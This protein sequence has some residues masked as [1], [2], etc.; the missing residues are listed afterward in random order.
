MKVSVVRCA[1]LLAALLLVCE[2]AAALAEVRRTSTAT[3]LRRRPGEKSTVLASLPAGAELEVL[4]VRGRWVRVR[5]GKQEGYLTRTTLAPVA[6]PAAMGAVDTPHPD[7]PKAGVESP[8]TPASPASPASPVPSET[9]ETSDRPP[10]PGSSAPP[11]RTWSA[12]ARRRDAADALLVTVASPRASLRRQPA[13]EAPPAADVTAGER[14]VVLDGASVA[15]WVRV[16]TARG[17]EGWLPRA[18]LA[19]APGV[20]AAAAITDA[21]PTADLGAARSFRRATSGAL[22]LRAD[23]GLGYRALGM[24][25]SSNA[26]G[27]LGNYLVDADIAALTMAIDLRLRPRGKLALGAEARAQLGM[28]SPGLDYPG[29]TATPGEIPFRTFA[30]DAAARVGLRLRQGLELSL[31]AG[32]HYDAFLPQ[33]VDN[34]GTLPRERLLGVVAGAG[35]ELVPATSRF[36]AALRLDVLALGARAQTAGLEDGMDSTARAFWG[37]LTLRYALG[38][39][40]AAFGS[41][42][43]ERAQT[44]WSGASV[45][46][47]GATATRRQDTAQ[48][49]Q[50]GLS[51]E[52]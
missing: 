19:N 1:G 5:A 26:Q 52:L 38:G 24:D 40:Y 6:A 31:R 14:L 21:T 27:G 39:R 45:R 42:E 51:A 30:V 25:L 44:R 47:P 12:A 7:L 48:L 4:E 29:P 3:K 10:R 20:A 18:E 50:L 49:A 8:A 28:S 36:S 43:F 46:Q 22:A 2:S 23:L 16:H 37:G 34:V 32:L 15:G 41:Y 9:S 33:E 13:A 17:A 11:A 35:A